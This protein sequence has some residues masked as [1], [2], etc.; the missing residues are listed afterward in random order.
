MS[1]KAAN[2]Q[3]LVRFCEGIARGLSDAA[4]ARLAGYSESVAMHTKIDL[5]TQDGI[6]EI[7]HAAQRRQGRPLIVDG[8]VSSKRSKRK[9]SKED[10][11]TVSPVQE[12]EVSHG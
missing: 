9:K 11:A 3:R 5:W 7:Y 8:P 2:N 1:R 12:I 4:A 6:Q 10:S